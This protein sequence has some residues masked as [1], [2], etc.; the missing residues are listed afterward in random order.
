MC[1]PVANLASNAMTSNTLCGV[2]LILVGALCLHK[3]AC[4]GHLS[5]AIGFEAELGDSPGPT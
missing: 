4:P 1:L 5:I 2:D 3:F